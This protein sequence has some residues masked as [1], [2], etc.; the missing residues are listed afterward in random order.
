MIQLVDAQRLRR[1]DLRRPQRRQQRGDRRRDEHD[2]GAPVRQ[3]VSGMLSETL[4]TAA[5]GLGIRYWRFSGLLT[6]QKRR[7]RPS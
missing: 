2:A 6:L 3:I 7:A 5:I 1:I 4:G